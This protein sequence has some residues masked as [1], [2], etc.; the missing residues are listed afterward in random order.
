MA[1]IMISRGT[2]SGGK[3]VAEALASRLK[4][5]CVSN[6]ILFDAAEQYKVPEERLSAALNEP[7][8]AW[9]QKPGMK[10]AHINFGRATLLKRAKEAEGNLVYHGNAGHMLLTDLAQVIRVRVV[11]DM[12]YR[13]QAAMT[14][15]GLSRKK[16]VDMINKLDQKVIKWTQDLY[17]VDWQEP[18]LYDMVLNLERMGIDSAVEMIVKMTELPDYK[19]TPESRQA[20]ENLFL[21]S[22]VWAELTK[23]QFT[24]SADVRVTANAGTITVSGKASSHK[25]IDIIPLIAKEVDGVLE[26]NNEVGVGSDWMW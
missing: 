17:G 19:P 26:V 13:I 22:L 4:Y 8:R 5:T 2:F 1:I 11:A 10:V 9:M 23:N 21:S 16:A 24:K 14:N 20:F 15:D 25:I 6:E 12:E 18:S 3:A 7:P